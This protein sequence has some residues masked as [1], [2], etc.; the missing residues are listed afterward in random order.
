MGPVNED[1]A[2]ERRRSRFDVHRLEE[3]LYGG[4]EAAAKRRRIQATVAELPALKDP[5]PVELLERE[6]RHAAAAGK[7][8]TLVE[9]GSSEYSGLEDVAELSN[10]ES[11][12]MCGE[13]FPYTLHY[14]MFI[15]TLET[16]A[17]DEQQ[18]RW[19]VPAYLRALCGT[20]AQ[21]E[22]GHGTNLRRIQTTATYLPL[23]QEF[24]LHTP[25]LEATKWWPGHLG[26]TATHAVV[27]AQLWTQGRCH[28]L[29]AFLL[30]LRDLET[31]HPLPGITL[32]DIGPKMGMNSNDNGF[33]R[34]DRVRIPRDQMLMRNARV[35]PG[36]KYV[37]P[38][39]AKHSY[40]SMI[41]VRQVLVRQMSLNLAKAATIATRYSAV[42]R[43]GELSS[44]TGGKEARLLDYQNQQYR[45]F[46]AMASAF[47]FYV[48]STRIATLYNYEKDRILAGNT[49]GLAEIHALSSG[50]KAHVTWEMAKGMEQ[51][52]LGCGG[53]G[54]LLS[55]GLP[56]LYCLNVASCTYEGDNI[57]LLLQVAR[58][59]DKAVSAVKEGKSGQLSLSARY[60]AEAA[61]K[62]GL[63]GP[64]DLSPEALVGVLEALSFRQNAAAAQEVQRRRRS[65]G[66]AEDVARNNVAV[67]L[68]K[69]AR[70]HIVA[71][72]ARGFWDWASAA[73][74]DLARPLRNLA[75]LHLLSTLLDK[76]GAALEWGLVSAETVRAARSGLC[77]AL[78]EMR[79]DAVAFADAWAFGD[80]ELRS[81]LGR[82]DGQVYQALMDTA[83]LSTLNK[84]HVLQAHKRI[85]GPMMKANRAKL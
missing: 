31:H 15:P 29:H 72:I 61:G 43:Q 62:R 10:L 30:Q 22:L 28:G 41:F 1:L 58:F 7:L 71:V 51:C 42:R 16:Q 24:E 6:E 5:I 25:N 3:F 82:Y 74:G 47:A 33:L 17:T 56:E 32:G 73:E 36:G 44:E 48:A 55:S 75:Q 60:L 20:Y 70:A 83:Q 67:E 12:V 57:V 40:S 38:T 9:L 50:L 81:T 14:G 46:P 18:E 26:K 21:T 49:E 35:E 37:P 27:M 79:G 63:L 11:M 59:L 78:A 53:H 64:G 13:T 23:S 65:L 39:N 54:Y 45:I 85:L 68:C 2:E 84:D 80:R 69:G 52:R 77:A 8:E 66:E 76:S 4:A 34:M 19:L